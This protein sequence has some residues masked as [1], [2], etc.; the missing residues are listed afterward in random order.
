MTG[1]IDENNAAKVGKIL[2]AKML[3]VGQL[4]RKRE[5]YE[6]FLKLIR[7]ET[8]EILSVTKAKIEID[9]GL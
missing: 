4:Y 5:S 8:A 7:V 6:L 9:L 1:L 2:G 3:F